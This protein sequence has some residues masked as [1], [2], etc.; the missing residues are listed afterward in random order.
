MQLNERTNAYST[1][2]LCQSINNIPKNRG[3]HKDVPARSLNQTQ[4]E[5]TAGFVDKTSSLLIFHHQ[6][7]HKAVIPPVEGVV[8]HGDAPAE[9]PEPADQQ[10]GNGEELRDADHQVRPYLW[11]RETV[12]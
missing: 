9:A 5:S 10:E 12:R 3:Q 6:R 4:T 11:R 2:V 8:D 7:S 1:A